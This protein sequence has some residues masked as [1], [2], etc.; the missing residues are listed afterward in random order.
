[1]ASSVINPALCL[2]G[3]TLLPMETMVRSK[4]ALLSKIAEA[5]GGPSFG[6]GLKIW[7]ALDA[8]V[9]LSGS[10]LTAFVGVTG[11][12]KRMAFDRCLPNFFLQEN[13]WYASLATDG[14]ALT[15]FIGGRQITG[16][17]SGSYWCAPQCSS[18]YTMFP[19]L[20]ACIPFRSSA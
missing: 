9:V 8:F 13:S 12:C 7:V 11:L 17:S 15:R 4:G 19:F 1:M 14:C 3:L 6:N 18:C 16:S 5:A 2:I 10:L 20:P